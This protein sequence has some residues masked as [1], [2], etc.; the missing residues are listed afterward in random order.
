MHVTSTPT[1]ILRKNS[2]GKVNWVSSY[3]I[4]EIKKLFSTVI[5]FKQSFLYFEYMLVK[6]CI[7]NYQYISWFA[8]CIC[9]VCKSI[10]FNRTITENQ[11]PPKPWYMCWMWSWLHVNQTFL[12]ENRKLFRLVFHIWINNHVIE[13]EYIKTWPNMLIQY[14]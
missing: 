7:V 11:F 6:I 3:C 5:V 12:D 4:F 13:F 8:Q 9:L 2:Q 10:I 1:W 14:N